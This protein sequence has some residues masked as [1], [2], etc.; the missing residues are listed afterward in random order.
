M[1]TRNIHNETKTHH[2]SYFQL[3]LT[4]PKET[5]ITHT[6]AENSSNVSLVEIKILR[7]NNLKTTLTA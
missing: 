1:M 6:W 3:P 2:V 4:S 5:L 7:G